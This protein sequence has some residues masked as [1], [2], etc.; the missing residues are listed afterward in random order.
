MMEKFPEVEAVKNDEKRHGDTVRSLLKN[1]EYNDRPL[2]PFIAGGA[3][4]FMLF[5]KISGKRS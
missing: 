1:G 4:V 2:L 3:A 5:T